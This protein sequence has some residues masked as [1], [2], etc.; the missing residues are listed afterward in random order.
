M[1]FKDFIGRK[2][3]QIERREG[4]GTKVALWL[5][6]ATC[7]CPGIIGLFLG[8][9]RRI[10][11]WSYQKS[12]CR[13]V[14]KSC[15][16]L[17]QPNGLYLGRLLCPWDFPGKNTGVGCHFLLQGIFLTWALNPCLL[18]WQLNSLPLS[19]QRSPQKPDT[20]PD[21]NLSSLPTEG[22]QAL[23]LRSC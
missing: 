3:G 15:P 2:G 13:L 8:L 20:R 6:P 17:L 16:T 11:T 18:H 9:P 12:D 5:S 4:E 22:D 10:G 21:Q 1:N 14:V 23:T 7:R 19:H